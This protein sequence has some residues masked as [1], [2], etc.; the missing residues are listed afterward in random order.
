MSTEQMLAILRHAYHQLCEGVVGDGKRFADG[1]IAPVI[2]SLEVA[3]AK[4]EPAEA[5]CA[6]CA[7][8]GQPWTGEA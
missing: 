8:C 2:R 7:T 4:A 6:A 1:L 5:G 3:A